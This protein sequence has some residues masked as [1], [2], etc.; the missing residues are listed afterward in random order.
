M[1]KLILT[2]ALAFIGFS[3]SAQFTLG[4]RVTLTSSSLDLKDAVANVAEGDSEFGY[5]FG[6]FMR[7]KVPV[8]GLYVQPE[9][10]LSKQESMLNINSTDV[11]FSFNKIDVPIMVGGKIGPLR[12]NAGP[13]LSFLTSAESTAGAVVTDIKDNYNSTTVGYQAGIGLDILKFVIDVKYEGSLS[14][15]GENLTVGGTS[16]ST[17][18]RTSQVVFAVGFKLF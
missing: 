16:V 13:S 12:I 14:T 18:Q 17:D 6:V 3:A 7:F 5:Q 2:L 8:I 10:L 4:P 15:F 9:V 1:K 11:D